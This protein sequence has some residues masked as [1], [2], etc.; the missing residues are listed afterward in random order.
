M[1]SEQHARDMK[2][3]VFLVPATAQQYEILVTSD[4]Y[5]SRQ[6]YPEQRWGRMRRAERMGRNTTPYLIREPMA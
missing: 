4:V 6:A 1:S 3:P 2:V 5:D